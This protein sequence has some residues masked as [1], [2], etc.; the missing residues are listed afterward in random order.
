MVLDTCKEIMTYNEEFRKNTIKTIVD[1]HNSAEFRTADIVPSIRV[2]LAQ[3]YTLLKMDRY[4]ELY[5]GEF[6]L[7]KKALQI[8]FRYALEEQMR[9]SLAHDAEPLTKNQL[10]KI[11][12][13]DYAGEIAKVM[14]VRARE[15][16]EEYKK[17]APSDDDESNI[18][19]RFYGMAEH[20]R[21]LDEAS[22]IKI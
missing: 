1:F 15:I 7:D 8:I 22:K 14:E 20:L 11:L 17:G 10:L 13:P 4:Q 5:M 19:A 18:M 9:R 2:F 16:E 6:V 3:L 21:N 12:F